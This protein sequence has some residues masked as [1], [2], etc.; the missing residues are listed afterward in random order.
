MSPDEPESNVPP[1]VSPVLETDDAIVLLLGAP[2]GSSARDRIEG[3]TRLEKLLFLLEMDS[4]AR[5]WLKEPAGF[6][7]HNFGP[8]SSKAYQEI[9]TLVSAGLVRD[10]GAF[11]PTTEDAWET[12]HLIGEASADPYATRVFELTERG[13]R[14]YEALLN[15]LPAEAEKVV[16]L[17][18]QRFAGL[19]LRRLVRYV[20]EQHPE[21]TDKSVI[22]DQILDD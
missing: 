2:A 5:A 16:A 22:R 19:P 20:Y 10:S 18:K 11:S 7:S 15:D 1:E 6:V 14:Y 12:E 9:D 13:R 8:F 21:Y 17:L 4:P 3:I